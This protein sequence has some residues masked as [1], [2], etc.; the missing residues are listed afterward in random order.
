MSSLIRFAKT[1]ISEI[2]KPVASLLDDRS[3]TYPLVRRVVK[4]LNVR[5][6][7]RKSM[8]SLEE[9]S[10]MR[11]SVEGLY[12]RSCM[13]R[14]VEALY[15]WNQIRPLAFVRHTLNNHGGGRNARILKCKM[16]K[17]ACS[18][19]NHVLDCSSKC[20]LYL[21]PW[22]LEMYFEPLMYTVLRKY[23]TTICLRGPEL[24]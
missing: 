12:G 4:T 14:S 15:D 23:S 16:S 8:A 17:V 19:T 5:R 2:R 11:R 7:R 20:R 21:R 9:R 10:S 22:G 18:C 1:Y 24:R 13:G 3:K 6:L